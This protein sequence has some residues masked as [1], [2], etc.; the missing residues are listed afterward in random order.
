MRCAEGVQNLVALTGLAL[1]LGGSIVG[2]VQFVEW[3]WTLY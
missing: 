1:M 3:A 2:G